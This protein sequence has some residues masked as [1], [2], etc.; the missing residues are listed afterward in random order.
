MFPYSKEI[1][2]EAIGQDLSVVDLAQF[3]L[4]SHMWMPAAGITPVHARFFPDDH[5]HRGVSQNKRDARH[6][7]Y[8]HS[9]DIPS[10]PP[11]LPVVRSPQLLK[12]L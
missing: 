5:F 10:R 9:L 1:A 2:K 6:A 7:I 3:G 8:I 12:W 11:G 4:V